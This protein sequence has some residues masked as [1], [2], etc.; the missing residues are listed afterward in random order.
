MK[1]FFLLFIIVISVNNVSAQTIESAPEWTMCTVF[2]A[3]QQAEHEVGTGLVFFKPSTNRQGVVSPASVQLLIK[4]GQG[5]SAFVMRAPVHTIE[6]SAGNSEINWS[7]FDQP[8]MMGA[9]GKATNSYV[10]PLMLTYHR[11]WD[12]E[13]TRYYITL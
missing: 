4:V 9:D 2:P 5:K 11:Y 1:K 3:Q 7:V 10:R 6:I 12:G 8:T 13:T